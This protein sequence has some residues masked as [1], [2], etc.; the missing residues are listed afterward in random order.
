[1]S[2]VDT[3]QRA[4]DELEIR[5]LIARIPVLTDTTL[6]REEYIECFA[7]DAIWECSY[8]KDEGAPGAHL[9]SKIVGRAEILADR[10][11]IREN[12]I[13]GPETNSFHL[14]SNL[15]VSIKGDDTAIAESYWIFIRCD[16][17]DVW[18]VSTAGYYYDILRKY[19]DG[20]KIFHRRFSIGK[21]RGGRFAV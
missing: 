16:N 12:L 18:K 10:A 11:R 17:D 20:W 1:M 3:L 5:N 2:G 21:P 7:E 15:I 19:A 14:N 9:S 6:S 13:Q 4:L 8:H